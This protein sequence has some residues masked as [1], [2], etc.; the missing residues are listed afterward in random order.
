MSRTR[1]ARVATLAVAIF[2]VPD[3]LRAV[4]GLA[5]GLLGGRSAAVRS[6]VEGRLRARAV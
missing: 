5:I 4:A 2:G 1:E 6:A 3:N